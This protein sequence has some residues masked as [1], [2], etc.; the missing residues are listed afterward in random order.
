M[1][2]GLGSGCARSKER[3]V[4]AGGGRAVNVCVTMALL[5]RELVFAL[6]SLWI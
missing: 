5:C 3:T 1:H 2:D 4:E 6:W